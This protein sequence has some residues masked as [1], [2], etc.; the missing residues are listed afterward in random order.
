MSGEQKA[1][2]LEP[3]ANDQVTSKNGGID[4]DVVYHVVV[5][6]TVIFCTLLAATILYFG[7]T[8]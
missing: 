6:L 3:P 1:M 8:W 4:Y 5:A 2:E 7:R